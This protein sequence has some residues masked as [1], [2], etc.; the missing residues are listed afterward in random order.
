MLSMLLAKTGAGIRYRM[1]IY[2]QGGVPRT[3]SELQLSPARFA[4]PRPINAGMVGS[5]TI[6]PTR[7][8]LQSFPMLGLVVCPEAVSRLTTET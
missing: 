7:D 4:F 5:A 3:V 6:L 1:R 2:S 8:T